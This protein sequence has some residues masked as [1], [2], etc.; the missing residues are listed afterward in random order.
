LSTVEPNFEVKDM[1]SQHEPEVYTAVIKDISYY[2]EGNFLIETSLG[3]NFQNSQ[4]IK[5][6]WQNIRFPKRSPSGSDFQGSY[7]LQKDTY[8]DW[9]SINHQRYSLRSW[10]ENHQITLISQESYDQWDVNKYYRYQSFYWLS[11]PGFSQD[12]SQALI[13][14]CCYCPGSHDFGS[15]LYLESTDKQWQIK[16]S[17]GL[18]NQ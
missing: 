6:Y 13:K 10:L 4:Q 3:I 1:R 9:V 14:I 11:R 7:S 17:Y 16:S 2:M 18:Y 12:F 5:D 15:L 8:D